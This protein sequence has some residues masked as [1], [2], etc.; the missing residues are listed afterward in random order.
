MFYGY[1][2]AGA[3]SQT[4]NKNILEDQKTELEKAGA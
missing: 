2:R 1:I 3:P 4:S